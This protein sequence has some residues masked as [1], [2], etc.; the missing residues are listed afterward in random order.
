MVKILEQELISNS[1]KAKEKVKN[2]VFDTLNELISNVK[3]L[4]VSE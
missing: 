3:L 2:V 4:Q 1:R